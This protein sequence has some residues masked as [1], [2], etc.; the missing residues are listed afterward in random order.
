MRAEVLGLRLE[1]T[2]STEIASSVC[3]QIDLVGQVIL[4]ARSLQA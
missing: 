3:S 2:C 4:V 1:G